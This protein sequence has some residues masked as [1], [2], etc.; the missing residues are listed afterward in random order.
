VQAALDYAYRPGGPRVKKI[1]IEVMDD[2]F[3]ADALAAC[4]EAEAN[5]KKRTEEGRNEEEQGE[6][7]KLK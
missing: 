4:E 1:E 5:F 3:E 7:K 6:S 2:S